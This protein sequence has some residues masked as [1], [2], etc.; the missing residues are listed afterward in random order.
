MSIGLLFWIIMILLLFAGGNWGYQ[1]VNNRWG[2]GTGFVIYVLLFLLG[3]QA[4]GFVI[5]G[6]H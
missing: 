6:P 5:Q 2:L 3:W 4:F 1:N